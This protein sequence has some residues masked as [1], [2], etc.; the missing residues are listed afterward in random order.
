MPV[1][2]DIERIGTYRKLANKTAVVGVL[3]NR[4][5]EDP[6]LYGELPKVLDLRKGCE[7]IFKDEGYGDV[8]HSFFDYIK[9]TSTQGTPLKDAVKADFISNRQ[10][11]NLFAC[12]AFQGKLA[13]S[14]RAL[15]KNGVIFLCIR[16]SENEGPCGDGYGYKFEKYMTLNSNGEPHD[17]DE[18]AANAECSKAVFRT[19][20]ISGDEEIKVLYAAEVDA[21]DSDGNFV[22]LKTTT[23][24]DE[25]W[26]NWKSV[27]N[28][29]QAFLAKVSYIVMGH[30]DNKF[31]HKVDKLETESIP[32]MKVYWNPEDCMEK[33]FK[34]LRMIKNRL[35][36]D[37]EAIHIS[38]KGD[39]ISF[40]K[41]NVNNCHFVDQTFLQY[42]E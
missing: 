17:E 19:S 3:P 34:I 41:E 9:K 11:I 25:S 20:L 15:R 40:I 24:D 12:T 22:E 8:F 13:V 32:N 27:H 38:I 33:I 21:V 31:I 23:L 26:L 42:F 18:K 35:R 36:N 5:N 39:K 10:I 1:A 2:V 6:N 4:L 7:N 28:Y 16:K 37:D 29:L 30:N 14:L